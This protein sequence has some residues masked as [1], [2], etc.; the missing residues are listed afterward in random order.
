MRNCNVN[1][2]YINISLSDPSLQIGSGDRST[3]TISGFRKI[4]KSDFLLM[5]ETR[6]E[7]NTLFMMIQ[8]QLAENRL[9]RM[10]SA[11]CIDNMETDK[12]KEAWR[13]YNYGNNVQY[14]TQSSDFDKWM[15]DLKVEQYHKARPTW[16]LVRNR[17]M[18][19]L[20]EDDPGKE[21]TIQEL[22][23]K[24]NSHIK[25]Q[26]A[27]ISFY[28]RT[29][30]NNNEEAKTNVLASTYFSLPEFKYK[31]GYLSLKTPYYMSKVYVSEDMRRVFKFAH[32]GEDHLSLKNI[33]KRVRFQ[34]P[35]LLHGV[36][37]WRVSE[38]KG[39]LYELQTEN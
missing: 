17:D 35:N 2:N 36:H 7:H 11:G 31:N 19:K 26:E 21:I 30:F 16:I 23:V 15:N 10:K 6:P 14:G 34:V 1:F 33:F 20:W 24:I 12:L 4:R 28:I 8:I 5:S 32:F 39:R 13:R 38:Y 22:L 3:T 37:Y 18:L 27:S 29:L 9:L 25:E